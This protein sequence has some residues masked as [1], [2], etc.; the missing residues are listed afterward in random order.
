MFDDQI[1]SSGFPLTF[2]ENELAP[3]DVHGIARDYWSI[4]GTDPESGLPLWTHLTTSLD[5]RGWIGE[6]HILAAAGATVAATGFV[7]CGCGNELTLG[8]RKAFLDALNGEDVECRACRQYFEERVSMTLDPGAQQKKARLADQAIQA[9]AAQESRAAEKQALG[10]HLRAAD[11]MRRVHVQEAFRIA[12]E[13]IAPLISA[14]GLEALLAVLGIARSVPARE[15]VLDEISTAD[16]SLTPDKDWDIELLQQV[17]SSGLVRVHPTSPTSAFVW[18][19]GDV[20]PTGRYYLQVVKMYAA[21]SDDNLTVR[22]DELLAAI[23]VRLD[24]ETLLAV[25]RT[26]LVSIAERLLIGELAR[27][28]DHEY[29]KIGLGETGPEHRQ[30]LLSVAR[31]GVNTFTL[32]QLYKMVWTSARDGNSAYT[33]HKGMPKS[34]AITAGLNKIDYH[35]RAAI[36]DP[37]RLLKPFTEQAALPLTPLTKSLFLDVLGVNPMTSAINE[38]RDSLDALSPALIVQCSESIPERHELIEWMRTSQWA[39][40]E[41]YEELARLEDWDPALCAVGCSHDGVGGVAAAA[42]A[43][44]DTVVSRVGEQAAAH[45]VAAATALANGRNGVSR[46]GDML[47]TQLLFQLGMPKVDAD[48]ANH[49]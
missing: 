16:E 24:P 39:S 9:R 7:C 37:N 38:V 22:L 8:S 23:M 40:D 6:S 33:T 25:E 17:F 12:A 34:K 32:G 43:M 42:G 3:A 41:F 26:E 29:A 15:G 28:V 13:D 10:D 44:Y 47:L 19:D 5:F 36:E 20:E 21:G 31:R 35:M 2:R 46:P 30:T 48:P 14:G 49:F 45:V 27:W 18:K 4:D 11:K 1:D